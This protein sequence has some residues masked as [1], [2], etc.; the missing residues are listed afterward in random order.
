M[1]G[2]GIEFIDMRDGKC[3][4]WEAAFNGWEAGGSTTSLFT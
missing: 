2:R 4:R 3:E 1:K